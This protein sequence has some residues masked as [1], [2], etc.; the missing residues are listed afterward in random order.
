MA[1]LK[2]RSKGQVPTLDQSSNNLPNL[3]RE[4]EIQPMSFKVP[5]TFYKEFKLYSV[6]HDMSLTEL[7]MTS[8]RHLKD[9]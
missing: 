5:K 9:R 1:N 8:F 3:Q 7:F 2:K 6:Q 4:D